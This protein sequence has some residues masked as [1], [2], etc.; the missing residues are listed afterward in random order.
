MDSRKP[1]D[2]HVIDELVNEYIDGHRV[3]RTWWVLVPLIG[4]FVVYGYSVLSRYVLCPRLGLNASY[5]LT[6]IVQAISV[7]ILLHFSV[8]SML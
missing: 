4:V 3:V 2:E 7:F 1:L 6:T 5:A 8:K